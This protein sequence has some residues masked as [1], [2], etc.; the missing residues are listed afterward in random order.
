MTWTLLLGIWTLPMTLGVAAAT[1]GYLLWT[2]RRFN[3]QHAQGMEYL[4]THQYKLAA[5]TFSRAA[6]LPVNAA[7]QAHAVYH[8]GVAANRGGEV[9]RALSIF[10]N[11]WRTRALRASGL[12][13]LR[14]HLPFVVSMTYARLGDVNA[15]S[16]WLAAGRKDLPAD[17][18]HQR[19]DVVA[20]AWLCARRGDPSRAADL[21]AE[22]WRALEESTPAA[23]M[24]H[25]RLFRA[26]VMEGAGAPAADVDGMLAGC[27]PH[28]PQDL[29]Q[30]AE[31]WPEFRAFLAAHH[32]V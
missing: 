2:I 9:D 21:M 19:S 23:T 4:A 22:H 6:R 30:L 3:R 29:A 26:F 20:E 10:T 14:A 18:A 27:R 1:L 12:G 16:M 13:Q 31:S 5:S 25:H 8:V 11:L 15:A 17:W 7:L 32:M 28:A 24:R